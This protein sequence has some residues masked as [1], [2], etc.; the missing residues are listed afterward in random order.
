MNRWPSTKARRVLSALRRNGWVVKR[1]SSHR[2]LARPGYPDFVFAFHDSEEIGPRMPARISKHS[3]Y[4][5]PSI[6]RAYKPNPAFLARLYRWDHSHGEGEQ[7]PNL[8]VE[9]LF[10][11]ANITDTRQ[12]FVEVI[13]AAIGIFETLV[14]HDKAF[15]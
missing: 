15:H 12:H 3:R 7:I 1:T 11:G 10:R 9:T 5:S 13:R 4:W 8:L 14:I 2:T 6:Y